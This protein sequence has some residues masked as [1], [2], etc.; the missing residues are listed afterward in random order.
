MHLSCLFFFSLNE[1]TRRKSDNVKYLVV[2]LSVNYDLV[3]HMLNISSAF[4]A[5]VEFSRQH[6]IIYGW[7]LGHSGSVIRRMNEVIVH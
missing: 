2:I 4:D 3:L 7:W 6:T 1:D 5:D